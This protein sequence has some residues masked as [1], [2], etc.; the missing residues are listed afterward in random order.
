MTGVRKVGIVDM[1]SNAIRTEIIEV[2]ADGVWRTLEKHRAAVRLGGDVF[3]HGTL[4]PRTIRRTV[5]ALRS[6]HEDCEQHGVERVHAIATSAT[7]D[8]KNGAELVAAIHEATGIEIDVI[9]GEREA[10]LLVRAVASKVD[11]TRGRLLLADLGGGSVELV[12]LEHGEV[13][14]ARS[15][16]IGTVRVG[17]AIGV[18]DK[19]PIG[20]KLLDRIEACIEDAL[21]TMARD[22][23]GH[24]FDHYI[25]TG[26]NIETIA[27]LI[28]E[29]RDP[30]KVLG[31]HSIRVR[32]VEKLTKRLAKR[33]ITE[34][35]ERFKLRPDRADTIVPATVIYAALAEMADLDTIL[36]PRVGMRSGLRAIAIADG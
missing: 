7:R 17:R 31:T 25:A 29:E 6:F 20:N 10:H 27:D 13:A 26:G 15:F 9:S 24:R 11:S 5:R 23:A 14:Y 33:T 16:P 4:E 22:L 12:R 32:D 18:T 28:A 21:E 35:Q 30:K 3:E 19:G 36:V 34:R 1:G 8:A 2:E